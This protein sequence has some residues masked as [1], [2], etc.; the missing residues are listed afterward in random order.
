MCR[1]DRGSGYEATMETLDAPKDFSKNLFWSF[2]I[3]GITVPLQDPF[4]S[5]IIKTKDNI[6]S[7]F[8]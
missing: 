8:F 7:P 4:D 1:T 3:W 2:W 5:Q 6:I